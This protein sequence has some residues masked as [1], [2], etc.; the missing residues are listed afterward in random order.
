M[1]IFFAADNRSRLCTMTICW[2]YKTISKWV[3]KKLWVKPSCKKWQAWIF[4]AELANRR[5]PKEKYWCRIG[6]F[7]N[8]KHQATSSSIR[9]KTSP[10][11]S[12]TSRYRG[13]WWSSTYQCYRGRAISPNHPTQSKQQTT[14]TLIGGVP[15]DLYAPLQDWRPQAG[16]HQR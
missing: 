8:W 5:E 9:I 10:N 4:R 11:G 6:E 13:C 7:L 15:Q 1:H 16:I 14:Q 12:S 2:T 3:K